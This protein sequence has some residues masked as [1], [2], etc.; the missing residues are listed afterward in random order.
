MTDGSISCGGPD[1]QVGGWKR[2]QTIDTIDAVNV[3]AIIEA[4]GFNEVLLLHIDTEGHEI[5]IF[6]TRWYLE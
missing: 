3:S 4:I 6:V 2:T 1:R 5:S